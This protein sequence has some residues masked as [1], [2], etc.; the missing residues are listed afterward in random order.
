[1]AKSLLLQTRCTN[2]MDRD[3]RVS[4]ACVR[5]KQVIEV[6]HEQE[7]NQA[8]NSKCRVLF[9]HEYSFCDEKEE[10]KTLSSSTCVGWRKT[11]SAHCMKNKLSV[12]LGDQA[13]KQEFDGYDHRKR[14]WI[15]G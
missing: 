5:K 8:T 7:G 1:M 6:A 11:L 12:S 13:E 4:W 3:A 15:C 9:C 14:R 2:E 10:I